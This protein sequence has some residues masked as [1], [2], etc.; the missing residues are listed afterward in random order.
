MDI[1]HS[2]SFLKK[3]YWSILFF[4]SYLFVF[5]GL[6]PQLIEVSRLGAYATARRDPS[7]ICALWHS[8]W[9]RWILKPLSGARDRICILMVAIQ[10]CFR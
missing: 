7:R 1:L 8:S 6:H 3:F 10:V 4:Y 9:Q 2:F 5:L